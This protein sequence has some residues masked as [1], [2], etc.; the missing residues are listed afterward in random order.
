MVNP[1]SVKIRPAERAA[2]VGATGSGKT[3]LA[4][5]L[6]APLR[7]ILV[8]DP[9]HTFKA[10]GF[11][12]GET[13][14]IFRNEF[15]MVFRPGRG[16]GDEKMTRLVYELFKRGNAVI[17]VDELATLADYYPMTT[18]QLS[19][20]A[21]TGRERGVGVWS[22]MQRPRFVPKVFL[23]ESE[24]FFIFGLR[25]ADDRKHIA[26]FSGE[27][28]VQALEPFGFWYVRPE[29]QRPR[30]LKLTGEKFT[31]ARSME[32]EVNP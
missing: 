29:M 11:K 1:L 17:Y 20:I 13:L 5:R 2:L 18:D 23:T 15:K 3:F 14:P 32:S 4:S 10:E 7:R 28:V 9:K 19:D 26:G 8:L 25:S 27:E 6:I 30:A 22:A 24:V 16:D 31:P 12:P 21:R